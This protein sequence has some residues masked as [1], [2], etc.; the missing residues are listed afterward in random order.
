MKKL[1]L[2]LVAGIAASSFTFAQKSFHTGALVISANYGVDGNVTNMRFNAPENSA[3]TLNGTTNA[4][5]FNLA[6]ELG[7][8]GWLGIGAI[9]RFDNYYSQNNV[10][11]RSSPTAGAVD[12]GGTINLHIIKVSFLDLFAGYDY[13]YSHLNYNTHNSDGTTSSADG[14]WSDIHATA[15]LYIGRFGVNL[16]LYTPMLSYTS[17]R[18]SNM[19]LG[20]Y[21]INYW[22]STG[23]G[24]SIGLQYRIL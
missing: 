1:I 9:G 3:Q 13:G 11:T 10:L 16:C 7:I 4:S 20:D 23:Y 18:N 19:N 22:K 21:T 14:H 5:N 15:R 12:V 2:S 17:F 6:A 8:F 24:A